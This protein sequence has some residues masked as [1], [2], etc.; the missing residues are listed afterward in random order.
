MGLTATDPGNTR[1]RE[2]LS[3]GIRDKFLQ[4]LVTGD[5]LRERAGHIIKDRRLNPLF[6]TTPELRILLRY[7]IEI[8]VEKEHARYG[9][10]G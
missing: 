1:E 2:V 7:V 6:Y 9:T 4:G 5:E 3:D 8:V 10:T